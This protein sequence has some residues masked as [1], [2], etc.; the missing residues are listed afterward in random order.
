MKYVVDAGNSQADPSTVGH[1]L[2]NR[3]LYN[4][5]LVSEAI[6]AAQKITGKTVIT[7][8]DMRL[9]LENFVL[10]QARLAEI[11]LPGFTGDVKGDCKDHEVHAICSIKRRGK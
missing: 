11:G 9:G 4:A 3:G 5:V 10:D 2:Y 7:G 6:R 8:E 1:V